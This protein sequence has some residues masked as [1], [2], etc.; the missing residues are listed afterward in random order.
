MSNA[1]AP[2]SAAARRSHEAELDALAEMDRMKRRIR[3][4][5]LFLGVVIGVASI[6]GIVHW[7][8]G[9]P[10]WSVS[11]VDLLLYLWLIAFVVAARAVAR[12]YIQ[13]RIGV[14]AAD[15]AKRYGV[16]QERLMNAGP[17][18]MQGVDGND[19]LPVPGSIWRW[20]PF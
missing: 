7:L 16:S 5:V 17:F 1:L 8:S 2:D 14:W 11:L 15:L 19:S 10:F 18:E 4:R 12:L 6:R 9:R 3:R 13:Y 20:W